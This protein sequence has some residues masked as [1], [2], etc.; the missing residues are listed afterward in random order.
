MPEQPL[1]AVSMRSAEE[2]QLDVDVAT[3]I[4][5]YRWVRWNR[6]ALAGA[7]LYEPGRFLAPPDDPTAHLAEE[8]AADIPRQQDPLKRVPRYS[9]REDLAFRVASTAG[10]FLRG[11][12]LLLRDPD[13]RW[14]VEV[15]GAS[16]TSRSLPELLCRA[17]LRWLDA[18][19][20]SGA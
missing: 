4:M 20:G 14:V 2:E 12:A 6:R 11:K 16:L 10:L 5:G 19:A 7:P 3:R 1:G 18:E 13:G 17:S 8:A 15:R 9:S